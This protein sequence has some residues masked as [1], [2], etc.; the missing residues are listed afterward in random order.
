MCIGAGMLLVSH[1]KSLEI[2]DHLL[3]TR[4]QL[5]V[6]LFGVHIALDVVRE[7]GPHSVIEYE[8]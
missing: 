8:L 7:S 2:K 1:P 3:I 5:L 6:T 4:L